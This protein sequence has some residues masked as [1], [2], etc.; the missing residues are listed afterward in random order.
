MS[1]VLATLDSK[2]TTESALASA[3]KEMI[4]TLNYGAE[5]YAAFSAASTAQNTVMDKL[6][7]IALDVGHTVQEFEADLKAAV[8]AADQADKD[9]GFV[10]PEDAKG[11]EKYGPKRRVFNQRMSEAK[12]VF[13][14][15]KMEP[16]TLEGK[17]YWNAVEAA[18]AYLKERDLRWDGEVVSAEAKARRAA[19]KLDTKA[20][21][22]VREANPQQEGESRAEW[23]ARLEPMIEEQLEADTQ[24]AFNAKVQKTVDRMIKDNDTDFNTAV[25]VNLIA[26]LPD[27]EVSDIINKLL[28]LVTKV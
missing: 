17:G 11:A 28:A 18:R 9:N 22:A 19:H 26:A 4:A 27:A 25:A 3:S 8:A 23:I 2:A 7:Y 6:R 12:Q 20:E 24:E 10:A 5:L 21:M 13:G 1:H 15:L 14:V 16:A